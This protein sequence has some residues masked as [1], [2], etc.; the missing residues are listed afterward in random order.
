MK[1][2]I[3]KKGLFGNNVCDTKQGTCIVKQKS[4]SE[5]KDIVDGDDAKNF[6]LSFTLTG[7][8]DTEMTVTVPW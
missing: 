6:D 3:S 4:C 1:N 2:V 5:V 7:T 8:D